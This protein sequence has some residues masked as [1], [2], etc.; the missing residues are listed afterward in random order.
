MGK[1]T[2]LNSNPTFGFFAPPLRALGQEKKRKRV[3]RHIFSQWCEDKPVKD[4]M[5]LN[6]VM[7]VRLGVAIVRHFQGEKERN[8]VLI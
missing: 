7:K 5:Y 4:R 2:E 6:E 3:K 1:H 8:G